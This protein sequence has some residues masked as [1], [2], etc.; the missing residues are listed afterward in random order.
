[1]T[2]SGSDPA[3][4]HAELTR[5]RAVLDEVGA[6]VLTKDMAGRYTYASRYVLALFG[7]PLADVLGKDDSHFFDLDSSDQLRQNDRLV[8]DHG[9]LIEREEIN[10]LKPSGWQ[11]IY[12]TVKKPLR[13]ERGRIVGMCGISTDITERKRLE[14][15]LT[16]QR[17]LLQTVLN[18][19]DAFI[20]IRDDQRRF[21]YVNHKLAQ[22]FGRPEQ[23]IIGCSDD[24]LFPAGTVSNFTE[25]DRQVFSTG[26]RCAGQ[27]F[28]T[29]PDGTTAHYW[30]IKMPI[31]LGD[32]RPTLIGFSTEITELHTLQEE[33]T[34]LSTTDMLTNL[35][36]RRSFLA[37]PER[38]FSRA[39]RHGLP[40]SL[41]MLDVDHFKQINDRYGHPVGDQVLADIAERIRGNLPKE[42]L[43]ARL[44]G[45][46]FAV[47]LPDTE[48]HRALALAER[49]RLAVEAARFAVPGSASLNVTISIGLTTLQAHDEGF[50]ALYSRADRSLYL[51]KQSGRNRTCSTS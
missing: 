11:R 51:A 36:N 20:Y 28:L 9:Q 6:Y 50:A 31:A 2:E 16:R 7:R 15:E 27:E 45:E 23:E 34:R 17:A 29:A 10:C 18:N 41:L 33:L 25:L 22:L 43:P 21:H 24:E 19:V 47:L 42:D 49:I 5:L 44:G 12:W 8:L 37:S 26:E 13:D 1:M 40:L 30:S 46:E 39:T 35:P 48:L 14:C 38:E 3:L 32:S 4:L